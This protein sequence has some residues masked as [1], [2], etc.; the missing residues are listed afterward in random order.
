MAIKEVWG[1]ELSNGA[2][3]AAPVPGLG[4]TTL[5]VPRAAAA[6]VAFYFDKSR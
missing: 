6:T 3:G 5:T 1:F 4:K 2:A